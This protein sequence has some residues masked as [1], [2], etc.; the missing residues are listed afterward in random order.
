MAKRYRYAFAQ[1]KQAKEG[2]FSVTLAGISFLLFLFLKHRSWREVSG[3]DSCDRRGN[4]GRNQYFC[5][6]PVGL[7]ICLGSEKLF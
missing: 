1:Q 7:W 4:C 3:K 2:V 5:H 6:P